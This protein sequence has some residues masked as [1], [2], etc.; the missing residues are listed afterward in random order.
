MVKY[1]TKNLINRKKYIGK[2]SHNDSKYLGS[3]TLF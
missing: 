1:I 3:G 2:D